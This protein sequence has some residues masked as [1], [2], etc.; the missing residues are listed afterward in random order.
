MIKKKYKRINQDIDLKTNIDNYYNIN[1][2]GN[3][4]DIPTKKY[5]N[6]KK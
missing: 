3:I 1:I 6:N 5:K 2:Y 4:Q